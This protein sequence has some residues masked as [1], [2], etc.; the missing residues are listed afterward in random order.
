M[1]KDKDIKTDAEEITQEFVKKTFKYCDGILFRHSNGKIVAPNTFS[2]NKYPSMRI[3][4]KPYY[5]HHIIFL[6]HYGYLPK[7]ID[8]IDR[9]KSNNKIENLREAN[10]SS[11]HANI[12]KMVINRTG[13]KGVS[14]HQLTRKWRARIQVAKKQIHIGFFRTKKEAAVAYNKAASKYF[15]GFACLNEV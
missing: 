10:R 4:G 2:G 15:G 3:K 8:H 7:E 6:Y 11:N 9:N 1:G 12:D 5:K 14:S 13:Y